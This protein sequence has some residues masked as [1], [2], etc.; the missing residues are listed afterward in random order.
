MSIWKHRPDLEAL[1]AT[2]AHTADR[3][4]GIEY[5]EVGDDYLCAR[6]PVDERTMQPFRILHGGAS[7]LLAESV[8]SCAANHCVDQSEAYCVGLDIN[9]NH[10]RG[11]RGGFVTG[12]A[13]PL[14]LGGSTQVWEIRITDDDQRL[15]CIARLTM[16]VLRRTQ[17]RAEAP[18]TPFSAA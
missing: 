12:T 8:G 13:R 15:I 6:M 18:A 10:V 16:S 3:V 14:H 4:L 7:V 2:H 11:A 1:R 17:P 9:A 5:S